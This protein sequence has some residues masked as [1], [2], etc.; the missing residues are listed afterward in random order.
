MPAGMLALFL[1]AA[2]PIGWSPAA[3][4]TVVIDSMH[5]DS[6]TFGYLRPLTGR[7]CLKNEDKP[8][9]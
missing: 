4:P 1:A 7:W 9:R 2:C 3:P 6:P 8:S 5:G